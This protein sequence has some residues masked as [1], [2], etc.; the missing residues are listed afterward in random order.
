MVVGL[1]RS[2][3]FPST[4]DS[5]FGPWTWSRA[6]GQ[7]EFNEQAPSFWP[8]GR[9]IAYQS[10]ATGRDEIYIG[11]RFVMIDESADPLPPY[12]NLVLAWDEE[13]KRRVP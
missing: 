4:L 12:L 13:L 10:D 6:G 5:I 7:T 3:S 9:W 1:W 2:M 11:P 8:D